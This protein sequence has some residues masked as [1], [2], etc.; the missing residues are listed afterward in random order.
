M[1]MH[2]IASQ[3]PDM[4]KDD[5]K[6]QIY[7]IQ[8]LCVEGHAYEFL[9]EDILDYNF[10]FRPDV[11]RIDLFDG[12]FVEFNRDKIISITLVSVERAQ[13]EGVLKYEETDNKETV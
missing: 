8:V 12:S 2:D 11:F 6:S 1:T 7:S 4:P 10:E 9:Y 5:S 13:R 3:M